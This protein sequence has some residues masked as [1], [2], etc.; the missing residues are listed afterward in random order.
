MIEAGMG[1]TSMAMEG[2]TSAADAGLLVKFFVEPVQ[3]ET[4]TKEEGR[5]IF[6]DVE[7]ISIK[8]PGSR[9]E[10]RRPKRIT[11][12][13]RFPAHYMKFKA[14]DDHVASEGTPL[15]EWPGVTRSQ[16]EE[17]KFWNIVTV[18]QLAAAPDSSMQ[19]MRGLLTLKQSAIAYLDASK[20]NAAAEALAEAKETIAALTARLDALEAAP[21]TRRRTKKED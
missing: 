8:S 6:E 16:V 7:W 19:N 1:L 10:I 21:K 3:N 17:M 13:D 15:A 14:R 11:D 9:N 5:P 12:V 20:D 18:E 4:K 2:T